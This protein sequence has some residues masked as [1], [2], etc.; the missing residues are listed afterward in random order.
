MTQSTVQPEHVCKNC[1]N[2]E[3]IHVL[4]DVNLSVACVGLTSSEVGCTP[5]LE[6]STRRPGWALYG[7]WL[8]T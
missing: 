7:L 5:W 4:R 1:G 6:I 8:Y 3:L 2:G